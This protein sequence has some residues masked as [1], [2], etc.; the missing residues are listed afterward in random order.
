MGNVI[1]TRRGRTRNAVNATQFL[2]AAAFKTAL[3]ALPTG[4][5][6]NITAFLPGA[7]APPSGAATVDVASGGKAPILCWADGT[8][9]YWYS[10]SSRVYLPEDA[11]NLFVFSPST[12]ASGA[13]RTVDLTGILTTKTTRMA[14]MFAWN[15]NLTSVD[16]S[17]FN[18]LK[19]TDFTTMFIGCRSLTELDISTFRRK[20]TVT[21]NASQMFEGCSALRTIYASDL[22]YLYPDNANVSMFYYC[23]SLVGGAGTAY[24]G[25]NR[26]GSYARVDI[27]AGSPGYFTRV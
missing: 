23:V 16:L 2:T 27:G 18:T 22:F 26:Y 3:A 19:V 10:E 25:S 21:V 8:A 6:A 17:G 9:V 5:V 4:G 1:I 12:V 15:A 13:L 24:S 14:G 20:Y 7:S 11:S